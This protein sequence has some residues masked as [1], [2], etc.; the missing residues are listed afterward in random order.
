M[1]E[2]IGEERKNIT[3]PNNYMQISLLSFVCE[4]FRSRR[5]ALWASH[6]R[7]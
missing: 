5:L 7:D 6:F 3:L 1:P 4:T 2:Q